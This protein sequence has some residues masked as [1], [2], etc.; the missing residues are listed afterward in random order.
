MYGGLSLARAVRGTALSDEILK[1]CREVGR[2][3]LRSHAP[4]E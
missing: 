1:A 3:A 2:L 4:K